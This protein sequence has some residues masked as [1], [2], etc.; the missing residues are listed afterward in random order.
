MLRID[1]EERDSA[2]ECLKKGYDLGL[3]YDD[4]TFDT[5]S[6]TPT[7]RTAQEGE[8]SDDDGSTTIIL[9]NLWGTGELSSYRRRSIGVASEQWGDN[10]I[11]ESVKSRRRKT[12]YNASV[13]WTLALQSGL[14]S[15]EEPD[16]RIVWPKFSNSE[17]ES[18]GAFDT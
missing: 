15:D 3:F 16:L 10:S 1:P 4:R 7:E 6:A 9:G 18:F 5:G 2:V 12:D 17:N 11:Q 14:G 8:I 13:S